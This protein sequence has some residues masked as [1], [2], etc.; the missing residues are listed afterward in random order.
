MNNKELKCTICVHKKKCQGRVSKYSPHCNKLRSGEI[1]PKQ[2][3]YAFWLRKF[4]G[5]KKKALMK[6]LQTKEGE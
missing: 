2:E 4:F 1:K 3:T 5:D 6:Y